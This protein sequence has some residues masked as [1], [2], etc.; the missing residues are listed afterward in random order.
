LEA[1]TVRRIRS[2]YRRATR[3]LEQRIV[4]TP[5]TITR[6]HLEALRQDLDATAAALNVDTLAA[7][8]R[9]I[10][11]SASQAVLDAWSTQSSLAPLVGSARLRGVLQGTAEAETAAWLARVGA[12]GL[13]LSD[14]VWNA[15]QTWRRSI[16]R[17]VESA[18]VTGQSARETARLLDDLVVPGRGSQHR[19]E[20]ARALGIPRDT[21]YRAMR[22]ARTEINA[23]GREATVLTNR[24]NPFLAGFEWR[25]SNVPY[26]CEICQGL[27]DASPYGPDDVPTPA[28]SHPQC[29][30]VIMPIY[31]DADVITRRLGDWLDNP[32]S[33]VQLEAWHDRMGL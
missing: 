31:Q 16:E 28:A 1:T 14:R 26:P 23:A 4:Q 5:G 7:L 3:A 9:G 12:D 19:A 27:A 21:S 29:R 20:T 24:T 17:V 33:D 10:T 32:E 11:T 2:S 8:Q 6:T 13:Q 15:G 30:C 25:R 18:V 22:L